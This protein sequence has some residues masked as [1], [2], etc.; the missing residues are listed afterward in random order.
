MLNKCRAVS[1]FLIVAIPFIF[2]LASAYSNYNALIEAD[3][4]THGKKYEATD[5]DELWADKQIN[6]DFIQSN[7]FV[8]PSPGMS[9]HG[10]LRTPQ[11]AASVNSLF[12]VLR[13]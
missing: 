8:G 13:C 3:F 11:A 9:L 2:L 5:T 12:S 6:P 4:I 1:K 10:L 7:S